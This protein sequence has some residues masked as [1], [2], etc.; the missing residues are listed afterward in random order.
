MF[1][2]PPVPGTPE[3]EVKGRSWLI[4]RLLREPLVLML[5]EADHFC[6]DLFELEDT[7]YLEVSQSPFSDLLS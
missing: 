5:H 7:G 2:A 6:D 1:V 3:I 4:F